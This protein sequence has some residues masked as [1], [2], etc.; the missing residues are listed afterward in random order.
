MLL[1]TRLAIVGAVFGFGYKMC[2]ASLYLLPRDH[3]TT[4]YLRGRTTCGKNY[5]LKAVELGRNS[6]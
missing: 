5:M 3:P 1:S 4:Q 6:A 2:R